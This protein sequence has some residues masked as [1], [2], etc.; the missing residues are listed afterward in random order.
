[1]QDY[2]YPEELVLRSIDSF[3]RKEIIDLLNKCW[4]THDGMWFHHCLQEVG[5]ETTNRLNKSAIK[6][7]S[8]IEIKRLKTAFG[9]EKDIETFEEF[10]QFFK[11]VSSFVAPDFM[12][13]R[14]HFPEKGRMTWEFD[15]G[16]C[17]AYKGISRL[18]AIDR[19]ECG[20]LYRVKC[21]IEELGIEHRF[22]PDIDR[23]LMHSNGNC[24]GNI[25][26]FF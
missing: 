22:D 8:S 10:K 19:Y 12:N 1:M 20:V 3:A 17:F 21:W 2:Y 6:S 15:P 7:L 5:I 23:C 14:W 24:S 18:G 4:M 25:Q 11:A 26:L 13:V 9:F 16:Q